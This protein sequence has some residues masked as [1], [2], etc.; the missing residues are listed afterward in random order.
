MSILALSE[1][2][3]LLRGQYAAYDELIETLE[4]LKEKNPKINLTFDYEGNVEGEFE[5]SV[6]IDSFI[7]CIEP[8]IAQYLE[9]KEQ[10]IKEAFKQAAKET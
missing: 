8:G 4:H 9:K 5:I 6:D 1:D 10:E 2:I 7:E 3:S